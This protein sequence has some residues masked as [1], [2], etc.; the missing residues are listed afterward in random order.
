MAMDLIPVLLLICLPQYC[1]GKHL[2]RF[3]TFCQRNDDQLLYVDPAT[4]QAVQR[5]PEFAEQWVPDPG[6]G[7]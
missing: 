4:Y 7:P 2:L 1:H 3:L 5:L 6:L